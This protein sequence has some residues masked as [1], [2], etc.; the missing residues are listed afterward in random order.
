VGIGGAL[1]LTRFLQTL[2]FE[3]KPT[4]PATFA[5]VVILLALIALAAC[6]IPTRR[7][8]KLDPTVALR[9]E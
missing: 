3:I 4:D 5:G 1:A 7:A 6:Y 8:M 2:L 9:Y